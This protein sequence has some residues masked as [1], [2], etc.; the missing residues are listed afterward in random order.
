MRFF[1]S[2]LHLNH[3]NIIKYCDR[4]FNSVNHMNNTIIERWNNKINAGDEVY[5]LGDFCFRRDGIRGA[6]WISMLNG[7]ITFIKGNHDE[8]SLTMIREAVI[9]ASQ[10]K[11][12][13]IHRP[14]DAS[15]FE[16]YDMILCGHVHN[17]WKHK[18]SS[19]GTPVINVGTDVW[20][21]RPCSLEQVLE[22]FN[23]VR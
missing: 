19:S 3:T 16:D 8:R 15:I 17:K 14:E 10:L 22:Y 11:I 1:T 9:K 5:H 18:I 13:L 12:L 21:F 6:D 7:R 20:E 2:D 4:P 23:E